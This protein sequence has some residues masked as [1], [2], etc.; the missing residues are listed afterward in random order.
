[1]SARNQHGNA[2]NMDENAKNVGSQSANAGDQGGNFSIVVKM[3]QN[4]TLLIR[5]FF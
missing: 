1:M 3:T 4:T 5:I 2:G